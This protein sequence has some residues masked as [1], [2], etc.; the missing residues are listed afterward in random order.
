AAC[1]GTLVA[2]VVEGAGMGEP[3][4][5]AAATGFLALFALPVLFAGSVLVRGLW[6]AWR[7]EELKLVEA[8]GGAPR[9]AGWAVTIVL[10]ALVLAWAMF[11]GTWLFAGW[12]AFK[13]L[14]VSFA[15]PML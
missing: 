6:R 9:L 10:G 7:P 5:I 15:E 14:A 3:L 2:G 1:G 11:Q 12:T 4:G 13:P 8:N